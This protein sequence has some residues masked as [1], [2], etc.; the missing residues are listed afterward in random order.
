MV[1]ATVQRRLGL[2]VSTFINQ[3]YVAYELIAP[4]A[5]LFSVLY[6]PPH[7]MFGSRCF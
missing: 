1:V 4:D 7:V 2:L 5:F 3:K 6:G